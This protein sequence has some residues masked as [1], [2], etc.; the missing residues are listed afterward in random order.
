MDRS[1]PKRSAVNVIKLD[2]FEPDEKGVPRLRFII[3][4]PQDLS[5]Q[6]L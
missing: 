6:S 1:S 5:S 4:L 3:E 2:V